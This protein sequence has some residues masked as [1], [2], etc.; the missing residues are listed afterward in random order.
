MPVNAP[1]CTAV[2]LTKRERNNMWSTEPAPSISRDQSRA[3]EIVFVLNPEDM[4]SKFGFYDGDMFPDR[5]LIDPEYKMEHWVA[6]RLIERLCREAWPQADIWSC[7]GNH[8][9]ARCDD[10]SGLES[11][12]ITMG[13]LVA[14]LDRT[15]AAGDVEWCCDE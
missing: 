4:T 6:H 5:F 1:E 15:I 10:P 13:E 3:D 8:N 14:A 7:G 11:V 9:P 2:T 12:D